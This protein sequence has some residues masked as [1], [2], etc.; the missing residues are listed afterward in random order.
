MADTQGMK[1]CPFCGEEIKER[2]IKCRYCGEWLNKEEEKK[3]PKK[4]QCPFCCE[5]IFEDSVKCEHCGEPL[6]KNNNPLTSVS[7]MND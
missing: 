6:K 7:D 4:I 5:E 2:A 1:I 3:E